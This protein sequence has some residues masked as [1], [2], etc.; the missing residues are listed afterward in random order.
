[1]EKN[2]YFFVIHRVSRKSHNIKRR[3]YFSRTHRRRGVLIRKCQRK[4]EIFFFLDVVQRRAWRRRWNSTPLRLHRHLRHWIHVTQNTWLETRHVSVVR[5]LPTT[6]NEYLFSVVKYW[7]FVPRS[8][9]IVASHT[10]A[11]H[12]NFSGSFSRNGPIVFTHA[13]LQYGNK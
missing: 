4:N 1:M 9:V 7:N 8:S 12:A 5:S 2:W 3:L 6:T 11:L 13:F 10:I